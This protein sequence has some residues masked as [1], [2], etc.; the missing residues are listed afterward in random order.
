MGFETVGQCRDAIE[1]NKEVVLW[2]RNEFY[3]DRILNALDEF[4][5]KGS[6][7][8]VGD[9]NS[10]R[11]RLISCANAASRSFDA[12]DKGDSRAPELFQFNSSFG[13]VLHVILGVRRTILVFK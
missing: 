6:P 2:M 12:L 3:R 1:A 7:D 4:F 5:P 8:P 9:P 13:E 11:D 10:L